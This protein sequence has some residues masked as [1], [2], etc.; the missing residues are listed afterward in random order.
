[1]FSKLRDAISKLLKL[2]CQRV[3]LVSLCILLQLIFV[4]ALLVHYWNQGDSGLIYL[5]SMVLGLL[6]TLVII[7]NRTNP[8]YK[9][10][11]IVVILAFPVFG[12]T[13]YLLFGG[14]R[15]TRRL[16]RKL[17]ATERV[18]RS[19]QSQ[20]PETAEALEQQAPLAARQSQYMRT[21]AH[22]PVYR[23]TETEYFPLGDVCFPR[24][25]EELRKAK[26]YIFVE[27]FI[28]EEGEMWDAI[29]KLL[30]ERAADGVDVRVIYDDW[31][32]ITKLPSGYWRTLEA[33]GIKCSVFNPYIPVMSARLNNRDHRKFLIID[34]KVGFTGGINLADEYINRVE[35]F[36]HWKD[37]GVML[38]GEGV[39]SMT[40]M[41]LAMWEYVRGTHEELAH[42]RPAPGPA[43]PYHGYVQPYTDS[44]LD[45]ESVGEN[46]YLNMISKAQD[47][48]Y[49]MTP[50]LI[51]DNEMQ[52]ALASAARSG[53][54]VRIITPH[55]PDKVYVHPLTRAHYEQL[56]E[57][58][59]RIYEYT[60]GFIHS[61]VFSVDG[62]YA[63]VGTVNLDFRSLYLH[64]EN[65]V[66]MYQTDCIGR[67]EQ[68]FQDTFAISQ[69]VTLEQCHATK[70]YIR[71]LRAC[72]R[73]FAP[74]M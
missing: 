64:F 62:E 16:K 23:N 50:Y 53:V 8:A 34:G 52:T 19:G 28:I 13:F 41:F 21:M 56:V 61:K 31:G 2:L 1:M 26:R 39:W 32:C 5:I 10:A 71:L 6:L 72:L 40:V 15:L 69:E 42:Y 44:P 38:R 60:P 51:I 73:M 55:V 63:T 70:W 25:L 9:V 12:I 58:G 33:M 22:C 66:W 59:V 3:V 67:I 29:L 7:S 37:A 30:R 14:N 47:H 18:M 48:V 27:Y 35:R 74:L 4:M 24:M 11:W 36:G 57:A 43:G 54:D 49:I 45:F 46:V 68:D 17:E 65:G 20:Q